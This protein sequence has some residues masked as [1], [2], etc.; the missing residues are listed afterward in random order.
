[1]AS[2][3]A[4]LIRIIK[5]LREARMIDA[6]PVV[7]GLKPEAAKIIEGDKDNW[8]NINTWCTDTI[9][10]ALKDKRIWTLLDYS[11]RVLSNISR[12]T[13]STLSKVLPQLINQDQLAARVIDRHQRRA[14]L[15]EH[16]AERLDAIKLLI[17]QLGILPPDSVNSWANPFK[18]LARKYPVTLFLL[19]EVTKCYYGSPNYPEITTFTPGLR[20]SGFQYTVKTIASYI[21]LVDNSLLRK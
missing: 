18:I 9:S 10:T 6:D 21:N 12:D 19:P 4:G 15:V 11:R 5:H 7:F 8:I 20:S 17:D 3:P 2:T 14:K 16:N 1:V 13:E